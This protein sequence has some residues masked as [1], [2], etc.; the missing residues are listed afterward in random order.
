MRDPYLAEERRH[1]FVRNWSRLSANNEVAHA[2]DNRRYQDPIP[3]IDLF[4]A[5]PCRNHRQGVLIFLKHIFGAIKQPIIILDADQYNAFAD[6]CGGPSAFVFIFNYIITVYCPQPGRLQNSNHL[7]SASALSI[8]F[9]LIFGNIGITNN[10]QRP[11]SIK[12]S[13]LSYSCSTFN[14]DIIQ[15]ESITSRIIRNRL[16]RSFINHIKPFSSG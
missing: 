13:I 9:C 14:R 16:T 5:Y 1:P 7:E 2:K 11:Y 6:G 10:S 4:W 12:V 15:K 3:I 8:W